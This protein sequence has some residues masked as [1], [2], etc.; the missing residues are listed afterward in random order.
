MESSPI[1]NQEKIFRSTLELRKIITDGNL[2]DKE[3]YTR[4]FEIISNVQTDLSVMKSTIKLEYT[5]TLCPGIIEIIYILFLVE[6]LLMIL[7]SLCIW[8]TV[9]KSLNWKVLNS[10]RMIKF[11]KE[12]EWY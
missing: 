12:E 8:K 9:I 5:K 1:F 7:A 2:I 11:M 6:I 4:I 10:K 3:F